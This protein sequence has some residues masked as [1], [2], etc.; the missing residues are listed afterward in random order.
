MKKSLVKRRARV[1]GRA[2][3]LVL[4][5]R[6]RQERAKA[7]ASQ[8]D[9]VILFDGSGSMSTYDAIGLDGLP[10]RRWD[11]L[12]QAWRE[13]A[14]Q[15]EGRLAAYVFSN[16]VN[17]VRGSASGEVV[18]LPFPSSDTP[19][20]AAVRV[21]GQHRHPNLRVMLVSD[22]LS[23]DGGERDVVGAAVVMGCPV[24]TVFVGPSSLG[25]GISLLQAVASATNGEFKSFGGQFDASKFLEHVVSVLQLKEG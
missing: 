6:Q 23:T 9:R 25:Q 10:C 5:L 8:F 3:A 14:P 1:L 22:G 16:G 11:A 17:P 2:N 21:A 20:V 24:D 13:L 12:C 18:D 19:M 15:C 4:K 7:L